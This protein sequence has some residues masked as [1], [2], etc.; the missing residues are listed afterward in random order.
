M[1]NEYS[2]QEEDGGF[3]Q[4]FKEK[5]PKIDL[6]MTKARSSHPQRC[7]DSYPTAPPP[8]GPGEGEDGA[9]DVEVGPGGVPE[10]DERQRTTWPG[11]LAPGEAEGPGD[12]PTCSAAGTATA[13]TAAART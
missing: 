3:T 12:S 7:S 4:D 2:R 10:G 13:A 6:K 1:E 8:E 5:D 9:E 11:G